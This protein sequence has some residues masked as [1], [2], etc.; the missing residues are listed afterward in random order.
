MSRFEIESLR[1]TGNFGII[2]FESGSVQNQSV[3]KLIT[4]EMNN[5]GKE[6]LRK[7]GQYKITTSIISHF[8]K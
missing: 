8:E 3:R 5:F 1:K 4:S 7:I 6:S 2:H